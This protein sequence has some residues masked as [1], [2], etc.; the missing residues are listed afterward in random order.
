MGKILT[1]RAGKRTMRA[2]RGGIPPAY[3]CDA[4]GHKD[5]DMAFYYSYAARDDLL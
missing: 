5:F 3:I 1:R 2:T 4:L